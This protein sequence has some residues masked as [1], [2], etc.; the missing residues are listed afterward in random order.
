[1]GYSTMNTNDKDL[2]FQF[3]VTYVLLKGPQ[4]THTHTFPGGLSPP[5]TPPGG[6]R[7]LWR[8]CLGGS[9]GGESP[10]REMYG[11]GYLGDP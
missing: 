1:M 8:T 5:R 3:P 10:P 2:M 11:Y 7:P 9:G 6:L 4:D